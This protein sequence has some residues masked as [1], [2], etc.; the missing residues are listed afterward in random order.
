MNK[1]VVG[2]WYVNIVVC[3]QGVGVKFLCEHCG[4]WTGGWVVSSCCVI[5]CTHVIGKSGTNDTMVQYY[6]CFKF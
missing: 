1:G 3:G 5:Y 6:F 4:I 2:S